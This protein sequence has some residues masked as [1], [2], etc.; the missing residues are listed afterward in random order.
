MVESAAN[1]KPYLVTSVWDA[2]A[3]LG[4]SPVWH[5]DE[6]A[7]YW[8]DILANTLYRYHP[9]ENLKAS[10][11]FASHI[12]AVAPCKNGGLIAAFADGIKFI[13]I[14]SGETSFVVDPELSLT[15][16]RLNDGC[17]DNNGDFW[18]GS[19]DLQES[20]PSGSFYRLNSQLRCDKVLSNFVI[21]N[22]PAFSPDGKTIYLTDTLQRTII[23]ASIN[24]ADD[25]PVLENLDVF[26]KIPKEM[27]YPDGM[28]VDSDGYLWVAL[29]AGAR[30]IRL[31][32]DGQVMQTIDMPVPNITKCCFGGTDLKTLFI[33]TAAKG[34]SK[35]D[36]MAYPLAGNL[37]S[38]QVDA[39]GL[40]STPFNG[41]LSS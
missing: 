12:S 36:R 24:N 35:E 11:K 23:S 25:T 34:L 29:F 5:E 14:N 28:A 41:G 19:M 4:E 15:Q 27:G 8:V 1:E 39:T 17:C 40:L 33:T 32:P 30:I 13:N 26:A 18:F 3:E 38:V 22:G 6:Q 10:W 31:N 7:L 21:S 9:A 37:F 2:K 20:E 16:N